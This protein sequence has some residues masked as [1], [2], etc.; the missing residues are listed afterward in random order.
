[1]GT[2]SRDKLFGSQVRASA[3]RAAAARK[4]A[5]RLA[6][7]AWNQRMPGFKGPA[8]P[9]PTLGDALNAGY[10]YLEVRCLGCVTHQTVALDIVRRPKVMEELFRQSGFSEVETNTV[11]H[12]FALPSFDAYYGPFERGGASTGQVLATLPEDIRRVVRDEV[13]RDLGDSGGPIE[14]EAE[15]L[16]ASGRKT[17]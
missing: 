8:Q 16:I 3:E 6:C 1:M 14:V 11:R 5:D 17:K 10:C 15:Y 13:R 7:E 4:E 12:T 2:K 9:S